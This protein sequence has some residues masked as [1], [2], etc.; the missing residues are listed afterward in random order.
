MRINLRDFSFFDPCSFL[1]LFVALEEG[2]KLTD[3][4]DGVERGGSE[5]SSITRC[6]LSSTGTKARLGTPSTG[7]RGLVNRRLGPPSIP[8]ASWMFQSGFSSVLRAIIPTLPS[9]SL[10][11]IGENSVRRCPLP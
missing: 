6:R 10:I 3:E 4:D 2:A 7:S 11:L 5:S 8:H 1:S 9:A